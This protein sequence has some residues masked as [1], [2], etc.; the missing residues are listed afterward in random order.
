MITDE[1]KKLGER[2]RESAR[3]QRHSSK[4]T[5]APDRANRRIEEEEL[6]EGSG[7]VWGVLFLIVPLFWL[8]VGFGVYRYLY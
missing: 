6:P 8:G 4:T 1:A 3:R 7:L 2:P 5:K